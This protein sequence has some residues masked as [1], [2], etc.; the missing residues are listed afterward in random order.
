M[1][2]NIEKIKNKFASFLHSIPTNGNVGNKQLCSIVFKVGEI[3]LSVLVDKLHEKKN[4]YFYWN[5]PSENKEFLG[6]SPLLEISEAITNGI[7]FPNSKLENFKNNF[8]SNWEELSLTNVPLVVGGIKFASD[9]KNKVWED[10]RDSDWFI[11]SI[12]IL[13]Q[14]KECYLIYNF[15]NDGNSATNLFEEFETKIQILKTLSTTNNIKPS[16]IQSTNSI[17]NGNWDKMIN[18]GLDKIENGEL[19]KVVLSR[20]VIIELNKKPQ[21]SNLLNKLSSKYPKCYCFAFS[22]NESV[23]IGA[24]PEKFVKFNNNNIEIDALA[25]SVRRGT[26]KEEDLLLEKFL[27]E[28]KKNR[29][30]QLAVV[31]FITNLLV[32]ISDEIIYDEQPI[33]RK[34]PNIQHLWTPIKARLKKGCT[35]FDVLKILNPTPAICGT[36]WSV[37]HKN[38][39]ELESHDRGLYSGNV[40]WFNF[41]GDGEFAVAIR[42]ALIKD[43][44][45]FAY[46]GCGIVKGSE[47]QQEFEESEIKLKPILSLFVNEKVYQS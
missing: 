32:D 5:L 22:K 35:L 2:V 1:Y 28:S 24:S 36:P 29:A 26:D 8:I 43:K 10:F 6:F 34:L 46:A 45:L 21:I 7:D 31:T 9:K 30:E 47:P 33:I 44:T 41:N 18:R 14:N 13:I 3:N 27:L 12:S 40:G 42:S 25:G 4:K 37:A 23:F 16:I 11:P 39:L 15:F 17:L 19:Q 38:I 20:E